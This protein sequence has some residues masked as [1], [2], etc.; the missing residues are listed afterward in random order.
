M[1]MAFSDPQSV[2]IGETTTSLPRTVSGN[3]T[4]S[5]ESADGNIVLTP[6]TQVGKRKRHVLRLDVK[7]ITSDPFIP[8]QNTEVSESVYLVID[9]PLVGYDNTET[10]A[11]VVGLLEAA[12]AS[13]D[14]LLKKLIAS[15]S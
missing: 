11:T 14:A 12:T 13:T 7:K 4:S 1:L 9:R 15:E 3:K 5:Y 10:L 6:S 8:T 2:K